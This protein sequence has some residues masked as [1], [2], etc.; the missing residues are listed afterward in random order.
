MTVEIKSF[1][2]SS[3]Q[4]AFRATILPILSAI[5]SRRSGH[6]LLSN[7]D[8]AHKHITIVP[9]GSKDIKDAGI[10]NAYADEAYKPAAYRHGNHHGA[11]TNS[12][13]HFTPGVWNGLLVQSQ[14][15]EVLVH[16]L[17]HGFRQINGLERTAHIASFGNV[18]EFFA[19]LVAS[20]Y[21]SEKGRPALGNHGFWPLP[22]A[23]V[24]S[25]RPYSTWIGIF[26]SAMPMLTREL[27]SMPRSQASFNPF[28]DV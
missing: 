20:I 17:A 18:E 14:P 25:N 2:N 21:S 24:L 19:A 15:D 3:Q 11:G 27:A 10:D 16:E 6:I 22:N 8:K 13:I 26:R 7:I 1:W 23:S 12:Q 4:A 28:R 5:Q 9:Y